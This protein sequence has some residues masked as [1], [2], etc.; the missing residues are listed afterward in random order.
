MSKQPQSQ[1]KHISVVDRNGLQGVIVPDGVAARESSTHVLIRFENGTQ[2]VLPRKLLHRQNDG[3]YHLELAADEILHSSQ[4]G[5]W[6]QQAGT[7]EEQVVSVP[8]DED[9][10]IVLPVTQEQLKVDRQ[11]V[12]TGSVAI[13]KTIQEQVQVVDEARYSEELEI[14]RVPINQPVDT[15]PPVRHEGE[16]LV[17]PLVEE[18]LYVEKRLVLREEIRVKKLRKE[19]REPKEVTLRQEQV[20]IERKT[21]R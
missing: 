8:R 10:S 12:Q 17:I 9:S 14:E 7:E 4:S 1:E 13:H 16:T 6:R 18:V 15:P 19:L 3:V 21:A 20:E 11:T 5:K 2:V